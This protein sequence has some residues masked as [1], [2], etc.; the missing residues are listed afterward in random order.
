M[1]NNNRLK[2]LIL[3]ILALASANANAGTTWRRV[4]LP[5][6]VM[7]GSRTIKSDI[8]VVATFSDLNRSFGS[9]GKDSKEDLFVKTQVQFL[10]NGNS[11]AFLKSVLNDPEA[12]PGQYF[13]IVRS[14][15]I[16][17]KP[18][19]IEKQI[20]WGGIDY[21]FLASENNEDYSETFIVVREKG[22]AFKTGFSFIPNPIIQNICMLGSVK[23]EKPQEVAFNRDLREFKI[24]FSSPISSPD[25]EENSVEIHFDGQVIKAGNPGHGKHGVRE[26]HNYGRYRELIRSFEN[27]ERSYVANFVLDAGT[28]KIVFYEYDANKPMLFEIYEQKGREYEVVNKRFMGPLEF[29]FNTKEFK[30]G[31]ERIVNRH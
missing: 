3:M 14:G 7:V 24:R 12:T 18:K 20:R 17:V 15:Y 30:D 22:D 28:L 1:S 23:D 19:G 4:A 2:F 6:P 21:D 13:Q 8:R 9:I 25:G 5:L 10:M 27:K 16:E 31:I 11:D 26:F 29:L